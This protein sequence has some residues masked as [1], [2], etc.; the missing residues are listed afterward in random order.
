MKDETNEMQRIYQLNEL[1]EMDS[2]VLIIKYFSLPL[3]NF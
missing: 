3:M 1:F 2:V